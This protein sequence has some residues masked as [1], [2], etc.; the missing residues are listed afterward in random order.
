MIIASLTTGCY[1]QKE[2]IQEKKEDVQVIEAVEQNV[3]S[4]TSTKTEKDENE[5]LQENV[6]SKET[7]TTEN[8]ERNKNDKFTGAYDETK[9]SF[10]EMFEPAWYVLQNWENQYLTLMEPVKGDAYCIVIND[11][12]V[13][14]N[15]GITDSMYGDSYITEYEGE[16][17]IVN[18]YGIDEENLTYRAE[19]KD[20]NGNVIADLEETYVYNE[21]EEWYDMEEGKYPYL[22]GESCVGATENEK[23]RLELTDEGLRVININGDEIGF[24]Q[25]E[26]PEYQ[27]ISQE[28]TNALYGEVRG[29]FLFVY[30]IA[31]VEG[32]DYDSN[33]MWIYKIL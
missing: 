30:Q 20:M 7:A 19:V 23:V 18:I 12:G 17:A 4:E 11:K 3:E 21:E 25:N 24:F 29:N 32:A 31:P 33:K 2:E 15:E 10:V 22:E 26:H 14:L 5:N 13:V 1:R 9:L 16:T 8:E 6:E 28:H 27:P